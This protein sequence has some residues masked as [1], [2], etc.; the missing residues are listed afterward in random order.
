MPL[1]KAIAIAAGF[2]DG[3]KH[4]NRPKVP[5]ADEARQAFLQQKQSRSGDPSVASSN[6]SA[7]KSS[8]SPS[9][10]EGA[11]AQK[12]CVGGS[13]LDSRPMNEL[14]DSERQK[15]SIAELPANERRA[16]LPAFSQKKR[17][18]DRK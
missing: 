13:E 4:K 10:L 14:P 8:D 12:K 15:A 16:E 6:S 3:N 17:D 5:T 1:G 2:A 7:S 11:T 9:E 18:D